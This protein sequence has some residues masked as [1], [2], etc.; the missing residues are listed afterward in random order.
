MESGDALVQRL[1]AEPAGE[2]G[3]DLLVGLGRLIGVDTHRRAGGL[4]KELG[5]ARA[6]HCNKPPC[7]FIDRVTHGQQSVVS[8]N[9]SFPI[10]E[11]VRNALA[12]FGVKHHAGVIVKERVIVVERTRI[13]CDRI[14]ERAQR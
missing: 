13:L 3:A 4:G 7:C 2:M 11:R 9:R 6:I 1:E 5:M 10:A 12:F 8:K 14:E